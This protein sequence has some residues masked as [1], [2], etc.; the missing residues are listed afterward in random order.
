MK[1]FTTVIA[2][3]T[4]LMMNKAYATTYTFT[5]NGLWTNVAL[6]SPS[7]PGN[8]ILA[9]DIIN[10]SSGS[11][12]NV[13]NGTVN[14]GNNGTINILSNAQL[15]SATDR[16][17]NN[18]ASGIINIDGILENFNIVFNQNI[19]NNYGYFGNAAHT[20]NNSGTFN[21]GNQFI[22]ATTDNGFS[23][24]INNSGIFNNKGNITGPG[25]F[26]NTGSYIA[27]PGNIMANISGTGGSVSSTIAGTT[28]VFYQL[29]DLSGQTINLDVSSASIFQKID[30]TN[31]GTSATLGGP[32]NMNFTGGYIPAAGTTFT[33]L[34]GDVFGTFSTVNINGL[35]LGTVHT[36]DYYPSSVVV[37]I[38]N[39]M[40]LPVTWN[41]FTCHINPKDEAVLNW[42]V[43]MEK[44]C[45]QYEAEKSEDA[46]HWTRI[47]TIEVKSDKQEETI[48]NFTDKNFNKVKTYYRIKQVDLDGNYTYSVIKSLEGKMSALVSL[49]PNPCEQILY[50][51]IPENVSSLNV[52]VF[53]LDGTCKIVKKLTALDHS[54]N[55]TNLASG[56]YLIKSNNSTH[57]FVKK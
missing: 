41:S 14:I 32:F 44:N 39:N 34:S 47:A 25:T 55:V 42:T 45:L 35:P 18:M 37:T 33:I 9:G 5:G 23:G 30:V 24:T 12:A 13:G 26:N 22:A 56:L 15:R 31:F 36:I 52:E 54:I 4:C 1:K 16:V 2:L 38:V 57:T 51:D 17:I 7:Y 10:I 40:A 28:I 8:M 27:D 20:F 29:A 48:Y 21:N 3:L 11:I 6:W 49:Y 19:I 50:L 46:T 43:S 53:S